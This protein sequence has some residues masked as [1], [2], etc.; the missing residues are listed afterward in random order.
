M[1]DVGSEDSFTEGAVKLVK[2]GTHEVGVVRL[3]GKFYAIRNVCPHQLGPVCN[4]L[5][6]P[7]LVASGQL[8]GDLSCDSER[9]VLTC[10]WHG[11]EFYVE[12][13]TAVWNDDYKL[14][15]YPV[16][17]ENGRILV[18]AAGPRLEA[19]SA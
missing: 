5:L 3:K 10:P 11:W 16:S 13:G 18:T 7:L 8:A 9:S 6:R 15:T 2:V 12:S 1:I 19:T 14:R 4:G 17:V